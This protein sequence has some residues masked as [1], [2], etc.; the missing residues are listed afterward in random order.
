M[1][2]KVKDFFGDVT[3]GAKESFAQ[4]TGSAVSKEEEEAEN[5]EKFR[6]KRR[7]KQ[8]KSK[9]GLSKYAETNA[10]SLASLNPIFTLPVASLI[11][12]HNLPFTSFRDGEMIQS[13]STLSDK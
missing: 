8:R 11:T 7:K 10:V 3:A 1:V 12:S 6:S 9:E 2:D 5:K 13:L 4:I